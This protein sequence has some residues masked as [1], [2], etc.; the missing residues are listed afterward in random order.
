MITDINQL[1]L[2][3][4]YSYADYL[5]WQL[6]EYVELIRGKVVRMSPAPGTAHQRVAGHLYRIIANHLH[7]KTCEIFTAPFDVRLP[8]PPAQVTPE[9]V[10]TIVQ[11]DLCIICDPSKI[12]E[13]GCQGAPEWIIEVLS[14]STAQKDL[15]DKFDLYQHAGVTEYWIVHPNEGTLLIYQLDAQGQYQLRQST[16][17]TAGDQVQSGVLKELVVDLGEVFENVNRS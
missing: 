4:R 6:D 17:F 14:R 2:S 12:D 1:D 5:S 3:K 13:R 16:P 15:T 9:K 8:L 7:K 10:N 11:P